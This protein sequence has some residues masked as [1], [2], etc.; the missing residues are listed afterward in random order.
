[1]PPVRARSHGTLPPSSTRHAPGA[2]PSERWPSCVAHA[3]ARGWSPC[4]APTPSSLDLKDQTVSSS[5]ARILFQMMVAMNQGM[6]NDQP[7]S[8]FDPSK[9][10]RLRINFSEF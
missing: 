2:T 8:R 1:M 9:F 10:L 3:A 5:G 7:V 6:Q 4:A